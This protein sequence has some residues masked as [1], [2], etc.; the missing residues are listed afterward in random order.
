MI[1]LS[2]QALRQRPAVLEESREA[3]S[4]YQAKM[5]PFVP[6]LRPIRSA[7]RRN[8]SDH[9]TFRLGLENAN[10][11]LLASW[12]KVSPEESQEALR[13]SGRPLTEITFWGHEVGRVSFRN[14]GVVMVAPFADSPET[15]KLFLPHTHA[16][17]VAPDEVGLRPHTPIGTQEQLREENTFFV[18]APMAHFS[19]EAR[20]A[21]Q[22][23]FD[24]CVSQ[25]LVDTSQ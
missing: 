13:N 2:A 14:T 9:R 8:K 6:K 11:L 17:F 1:Q 18:F 24:T 21:I 22:A 19:D 15:R 7:D 5:L 16:K 10:H 23:Q 12:V 25:L 3:Y 4:K 20:H